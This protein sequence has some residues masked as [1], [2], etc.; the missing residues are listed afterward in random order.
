[1]FNCLTTVFA[2]W[3]QTIQVYHRK[4]RPHPEETFLK[5]QNGWGPTSY[6]SIVLERIHNSAS[7]SP[8]S[9]SL[10]WSVWH[11]SGS[12]AVRIPPLFTMPEWIHLRLNDPEYIARLPPVCIAGAADPHIAPVLSK[13]VSPF[14]PLITLVSMDTELSPYRGSK[15]LRT[16]RSMAFFRVLFTV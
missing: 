5:M 14:N 2:R 1:M 13:L 6:S 3:R 11:V 16:C 9:E 10:Y 8:Q 15:P 7:D 4:Y 12:T